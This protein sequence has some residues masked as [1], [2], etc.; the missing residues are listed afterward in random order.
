MFVTGDHP[1]DEMGP[2]DESI[3]MPKYLLYTKAQLI[4]KARRKIK[5]W[6]EG[7]NYQEYIKDPEAY[8]KANLNNENHIKK[9]EGLP[10]EAAMTDEEIYQKEI[11]WYES[12]M[13]GKRGGVW[14]TYNPKSKWDW[15]EVGG[16]WDGM[17]VLKDGRTVN[18]AKKNEVDWS[19]TGKAFGILHE[20]K[21]HENAKMGWFGMTS[22][23][24]SEKRWEKE[25]QEVMD[26]IPDDTLITVIDCHI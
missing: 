9:L 17:L 16:R 3:E 19:K 14:S 11:D 13:V 24:K 18:E 4:A 6:M 25:Y 22:D 1:E 26:S 21:W 8:K 15:F 7:E 23:E 20:G 10:Q 12:D 2:F 5:E